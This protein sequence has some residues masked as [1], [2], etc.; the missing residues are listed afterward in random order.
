MLE[1]GSFRNKTA[2][3]FFMIIFGCSL[4]IVS[5]IHEGYLPLNMFWLLHV[6]WQLL[7]K[8]D[9]EFRSELFVKTCLSV[10][11]HYQ[12][13]NQNRLE[14]GDLACKKRHDFIT[15]NIWYYTLGPVLKSLI[16]KNVFYN[17]CS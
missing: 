7:L 5:F 14:A 1:E 9:Y 8:E 2:D 15:L 13:F 3:F 11:W 12:M 6:N 4:M 10:S 17:Y 16:L